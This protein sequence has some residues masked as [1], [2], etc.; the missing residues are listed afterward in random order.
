MSIAP[1]AA[2]YVRTSPSCTALRDDGYTVTLEVYDAGIMVDAELA[3]SG[4]I[5]RHP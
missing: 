2:I 3:L 5:K 4:R 1:S